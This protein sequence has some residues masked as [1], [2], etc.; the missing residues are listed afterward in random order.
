MRIRRGWT[1]GDG[2]RRRER[3]IDGAMFRQHGPRNAYI[4][5]IGLKSRSWLV[6]VRQGRE[7]NRRRLAY[8]LRDFLVQRLWNFLLEK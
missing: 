8:C 3:E 2:V 1:R 6:V 5:E 4:I 7:P